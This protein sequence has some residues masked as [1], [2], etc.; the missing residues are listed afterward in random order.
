MLSH[1]S[2]HMTKEIILACQRLGG[3]AYVKSDRTG[4][5]WMLLDKWEQGKY[6]A[7]SVSGKR[8]SEVSWL[9]RRQV[10]WLLLNKPHCFYIG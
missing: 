4:K 1:K 8:R 3:T 10:D 6:A 2:I 9:T 5:V 7:M